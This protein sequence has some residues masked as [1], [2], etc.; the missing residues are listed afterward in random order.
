MQDC[1]LNILFITSRADIGG[2]PKHLLDLISSENY[3][4]IKKYVALPKNYELSEKISSKCRKC[5]SIPH[6]KLSFLKLIELRNFCRENSIDLVHS[7]GRGAGVYSRLLALFGIKV[8]HTFHGIHHENTAIGK[9]KLFIDVFLK[10]MSSHYI[11]VSEDERQKA[12]KSGVCE[13][14]FVIPNGVAPYPNN[15][16]QIRPTF[17]A[18]VLARLSY[19]KGIDILISYIKDEEIKDIPFVIAGSG[20]EEESLKEKSKQFENLAFLGKTLEPQRFILDCD[21]FISTSR[22]EGFPL[23]V[24]EAMACG[25]PCLLPDVTGHGLFKETHSALFYDLQ[26]SKDFKEKLF[27]LKNNENLR[28]ELSSTAYNLIKERLSVEKMAQDTISVYQSII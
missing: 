9:I 21:V 25:I 16:Y 6:R 18:G 2:G 20:E 7:H 4:N 22:W 5:I 10:T 15:P 13:D 28:L 3:E 26:S 11:C 23:S 14:S 19:Q 17:K 27:E 24:L 12:M 1:R 8:V